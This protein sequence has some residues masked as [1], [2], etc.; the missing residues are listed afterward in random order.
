[1]SANVHQHIV[2]TLVRQIIRNP[3]KPTKFITPIR[4]TGVPVRHG[5]EMGIGRLGITATVNNS[6]LLVAPQR[7]QPYKTR[8]ETKF[9]VQGQ[10]VFGGN[11][12][13]WPQPVVV[14][15]AKRHNRIQAIIAAGQYQR[16]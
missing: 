8:I 15:V 6:Q 14:I 3:A 7:L 9:C 12:K 2:T 10:K 16:H 4:R 1:M 13:C 11:A 5:S